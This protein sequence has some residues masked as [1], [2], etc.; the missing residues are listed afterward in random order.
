M[1]LFTYYTSRWVYQKN[2]WLRVV[3]SVLSVYFASGLYGIVL[4]VLVFTQRDNPSPELFSEIVLMI[5]FGITFVPLLWLV[6]PA[7][8]F[9]HLLIAQCEKRVKV[10]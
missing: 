8:F 3:W 7:S 2:I 1:G 10:T 9:N 6:Y 4:S 5:W